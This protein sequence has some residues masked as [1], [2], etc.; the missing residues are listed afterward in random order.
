MSKEALQA[1]IQDEQTYQFASFSHADAWELGHDL[2]AACAKM[3]GPLA[4]QIEI[5]HV[6][7]FRYFPDGTGKYHEQWLRRKLNTV[8]TVEKSSLRVFY[9]LEQNH[10]TLEE[11]WLLSKQDYADCG[12]AFPI[13]I[14]NGSVIGV[15]AVSGLPHLQDNAALMEG[16]RTFWEKHPA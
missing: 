3:P 2:V 1:C 12:G 16:I 10:E 9:E 15:A 11:D 4:V 14:R 8:N 5:N 7:V 6:I 13:R